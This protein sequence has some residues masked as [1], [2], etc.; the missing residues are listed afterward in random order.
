MGSRRCWQG[1]EWRYLRYVFLIILQPDD[2]APS[3]LHILICEIFLRVLVDTF[4]TSLL[5][6]PPD[7][8]IIAEGIHAN[9]TTLDSRRFAEEFVRRRKLA[10]Q[11]KLAPDSGST[12]GGGTGGWNS[13]AGGRGG[14]DGDGRGEG[15]K[16]GFQVVGAKKK[17]KR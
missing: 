16:E 4:V 9:S 8:D 10:D 14:G 5:S 3:L 17:G 15:K 13:V 2:E 7:T 12:A 6:L 11:G 1:V